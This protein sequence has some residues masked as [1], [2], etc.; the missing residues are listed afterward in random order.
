MAEMKTALAARVYGI[1]EQYNITQVTVHNIINSYI[2]YCKNLL[3]YGRRVDFLGLVSLIP[4][5]ITNDCVV[6]LAYDCD[7]LAGQLG[8]PEHTVFVIIREYLESLKEEVLR[9][10]SVDIRGIVT[11]N[12]RYEN[13]VLTTVHS[14]IST[15]FRKTLCNLDTEVSSIR[16]HTSKLLKYRIKE[17]I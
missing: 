8:L 7:I 14:A 15:S 9:G 11:I 13:G 10:K 4:D 17:A 6:T 3:L 16:V 2:A 5:V 1:A 12:P